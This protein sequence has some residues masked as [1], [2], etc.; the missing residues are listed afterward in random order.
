[1][2]PQV[3]PTG[4]F[5]DAADYRAKFPDGRIG[6]DPALAKAEDGAELIVLAAKGLIEDYRRFL[7]S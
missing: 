3:A 1:M 6:S 4:R 2:S 7:A 5:T